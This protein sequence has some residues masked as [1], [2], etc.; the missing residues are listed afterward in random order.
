M[1]GDD[2]SPTHT[3]PG[4]KG[5]KGSRRSTGHVHSGPTATLSAHHSSN[6][7][8]TTGFVATQLVSSAVSMA[9]LVLTTFSALAFSFTK[10]WSTRYLPALA[11]NGK[12]TERN[13]RA[14][15]LNLQKGDSLSL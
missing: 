5:G 3:A 7:N 4:G 11:T 15:Q 2:P 6:L 14:Q 8:F 1:F 10:R 13:A 12:Y 9:Q